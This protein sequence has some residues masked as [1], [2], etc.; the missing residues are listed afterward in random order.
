MNGYELEDAC[1]MEEVLIAGG[2]MEGDADVAIAEINN[3]INRVSSID[4][5]RGLLTTVCAKCAVMFT[6]DRD[7]NI[8]PSYRIPCGT[9]SRIT[10]NPNVAV[11]EVITPRGAQQYFRTTPLP[12]GI[13]PKSFTS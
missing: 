11:L 10:R 3:H 5:D 6:I 1:L 9:D 8:K 13:L 12:K 2:S 7:Q 4:S